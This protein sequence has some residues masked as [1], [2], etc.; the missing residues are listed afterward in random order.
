L[1]A[2]GADRH[3]R[4]FLS[5]V[6]AGTPVVHLVDR[7]AETGLTRRGAR[8]RIFDATSSEFSARKGSFGARRAE[9]RGRLERDVS[10]LG[11]WTLDCLSLPDLEAP[12]Q[13]PPGLARFDHVVYVASRS[14]ERRVGL[15]CDF[16][17]VC[18]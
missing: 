16:P 1:V 14:D 13:G 9:Y 7:P 17:L 4:R 10:V 12:D 2:R 5:Q 3:G 8:F 15:G 6:G 18:V 11:R